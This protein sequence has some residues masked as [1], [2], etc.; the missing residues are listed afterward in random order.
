MVF[1]NQPVMSHLQ[2]SLYRPTCQCNQR[3]KLIYPSCGAFAAGRIPENQ[4]HDVIQRL[5]S[6]FK[7][8]QDKPPGRPY[9]WPMNTVIEIEQAIERLPEHDQRKIAE[10][11]ED[12]RLI[13][14]SS[15]VLS[16]IYDEEDA[17]ENQ[18]VEE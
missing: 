2:P 13:V 10:W 3:P 8:K 4:R 1:D 7:N 12:H 5:G 11:F 18:L 15:A 17:G 9:V 14:A 16:S 6:V